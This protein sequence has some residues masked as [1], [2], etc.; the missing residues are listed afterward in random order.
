MKCTPSGVE[1]QRQWSH[2]PSLAQN[3]PCWPVFAGDS[4]GSPARNKFPV[5]QAAWYTKPLPTFSDALA[6]VRQELWQHL[7]FQPSHFRGD[8]RNIPV[9]SLECLRN[10]VCY[11]V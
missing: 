11:T 6:M 8:V 2:Q 9:K 4:A 10:A 3:R 5:R 7:Y 1:T